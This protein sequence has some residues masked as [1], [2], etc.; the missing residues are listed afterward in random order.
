MNTRCVM[1]SEHT[2][3]GLQREE[4]ARIGAGGSL[5]REKGKEPVG[6][7]LTGSFSLYS[8][9]PVE[10]RNPSSYWGIQQ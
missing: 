10:A 1:G 2:S 4:E 7:V 8:Y 3:L 9:P 5:I 6:L